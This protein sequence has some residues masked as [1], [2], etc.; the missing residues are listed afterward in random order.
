MFLDRHILG[1]FPIPSL[2]HGAVPGLQRPV[3]TELVVEEKLLIVEGVRGDEHL[4]KVVAQLVRPTC[5]PAPPP[6]A[7]SNSG[8]PPAS[9]SLGQPR[10]ASASLGQLANM[11]WLAGHTLST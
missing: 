7:K 4:W 8:R 5:P 9:A 6:G 1:R 3:L 10:P 2:M 11:C